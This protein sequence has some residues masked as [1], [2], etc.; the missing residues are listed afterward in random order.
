MLISTQYDRPTQEGAHSFDLLPYQNVLLQDQRHLDLAYPGGYGSGKTW[1]GALWNKTRAEINVGCESWWIAPNYSLTYEGFKACIEILELFGWVEGAHF[2]ATRSPGNLSI[3]YL[4]YH[5][6]TYFKSTNTNLQ[7]ATIAHLVSD[8]SG[9]NNPENESKAFNRVRDPK[10]KLHQRLSVGAPQGLNHYF[11]RFSGTNYQSS[12]PFRWNAKKLVL[13]FRTFW[14]HHLPK[15][16]VADLIDEY[17]HDEAFIKSWVLGLFVALSQNHCFKYDPLQHGDG[18]GLNPVCPEV[19]V[20]W[21]FNYGQ[22]AFVG[23]QRMLDKWC[24]V[25]EAPNHVQTTDDACTELFKKIPAHTWG[26]ARIIID[27]DANGWAGNTRTPT[28]D[29]DIIRERFEKAGYRNFEIIAP[30]SNS[31]V[32]LRV[33]AT[34]RLFNQN[35][36]VLH[37]DMRY[38]KEGL[39]KTTWDNH[40]G[41]K[42]VSGD[43]WTH[44]PD[45]MSYVVSRQEPVGT[46]RRIISKRGG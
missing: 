27:G 8:E 14:N 33:M 38:T 25:F 15:H 44:R 1:F 3:E 5:H 17:G 21:D 45:A 6:V 4:P 37:K 39:Q 24:G 31:R 30:R 35:R 11:Q 23:L 7:A 41:I 2:K 26:N 43:T 18:P 40:G 20:G 36:L 22:V 13:H 28:S 9:D 12:G 32:H 16:Y 34:N 10:A 19:Y 42:K 46:E 29:Y